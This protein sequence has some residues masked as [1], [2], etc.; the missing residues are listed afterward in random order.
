MPATLDHLV[1]KLRN[2]AAMITFYTD[3]LGLEAE[4]LE[5]YRNGR[6][7]FPSIRINPTTV[8]DLFPTTL[9]APVTPNLDH[10]CL[11]LDG[12]S[13]ELVRNRLTEH[14]VEIDGPHTRWGALGDGQSIYVADP[15]GNSVELK[16]HDD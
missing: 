7:P 5:D 16:T 4:R 2:E 13:W 9:E 14:G 10:F 8:I 3:I 1:L 12:A 11:T 6:A 15:D